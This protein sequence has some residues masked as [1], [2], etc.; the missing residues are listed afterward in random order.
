METAEILIQLRNEITE[1]RR[2]ILLSNSKSIVTD[3]W[4]TR[5]EVME[6]LD[7]EATQMAEFEK[8]KEIAVSRIGR[9]KFIHRDS[10]ENFLEKNKIT[11]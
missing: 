5:K 9:R 2:L 4:L 7:Y 3:K 11:S 8:H 10:F 1:L 6:F